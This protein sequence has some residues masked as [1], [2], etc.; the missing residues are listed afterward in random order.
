M[1]SA[2]SGGLHF[3]SRLHPIRPDGEVVSEPLQCRLGVRSTATARASRVAGS[4]R[5]RLLMHQRVVG[6]RSASDA[7]VPERGQE[8]PRHLTLKG[9]RWT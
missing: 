1:I 9:T 2:M 7:E 8:A 4:G 3:L 6:D 5:F